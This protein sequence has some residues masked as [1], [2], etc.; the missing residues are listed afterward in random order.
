V[1]RD[2]VQAT[3][4][5]IE[6]GFDLLGI[7]MAHGYLLASFISP[8]TNTREDE[9]GGSLAERRRFRSRSSMPAERPGLANAR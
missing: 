6:A 8:L 5:A 7:H 1:V 3:H 4:H 9:Y 2:Y